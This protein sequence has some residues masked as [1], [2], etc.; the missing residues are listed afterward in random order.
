MKKIIFILFF[1]FASGSLYAELDTLSYWDKN[2]PTFVGFNFAQ[3]PLQSA[4]FVPEAPCYIKEIHAWYLG[5]PGSAVIWLLDQAGG[6]FLPNAL[7][8]TAGQ[9]NINA[10]SFNVNPPPGQIGGVR[11][12]L[13]EPY[14]MT[15]TQFYVISGNH[16]QGLLLASDTTLHE[17]FCEYKEGDSDVQWRPQ[18]LSNTNGDWMYGPYAYL[19]DV[20]VEYPEKESK[21]YLQDITSQVELPT[22]MGRT[23]YAW[24]DFDGDG[25]LDF[26]NGGRYFKNNEGESFTEMTQ[27]LGL[28]GS[29]SG[30]AFV[31]MDND[32]DLDIVLLK[33]SGAKSYLYTNDGEGGLTETQLEGIPDLVDPTCFSFADINGDAYPDLFIGQLW[34]PYPDPQPNYFL[35]NNQNG[36][37]DYL[38]DVCKTDGDKQ[39]RGSQFV[40]FDDDGDLDLYVT[41]YFLQMDELWENEGDLNF[42]NIIELTGISQNRG[43]DHNYPSNHGTGVDWYDYDNDG[44]MDILLCQF[45][46]PRFIGESIDHRPTT[47]YKNLEGWYDFEDTYDP[48]TWTSN[49]GLGFTESYAGASW[50]DANNDGLAD[51]VNT[52]FYRCQYI[53]FYEQQPDHTFENKTFEYGLEWIYTGVDACWVDYD[54][55][56]RLDLA[57]SKDNRFVLFKNMTPAD[58]NWVEIDLEASSGNKYAI[59]SRVK[60]YAGDD[61]YMQEVNCG[62]GQKM[63]RPYRLHFGLG[64]HQT[65][66][67]I[68][69]RWHGKTE[70]TTYAGENIQANS[71]IKLTETASDVDEI[72]EGEFYLSESRPNPVENAAALT[73]G[74]P[75]P[76][77]I[78]LEIYDSFGKLIRTLDSGFKNAGEHN[79]TFNVGDAASGAYYLKLSSGEQS[80]TTRLIISK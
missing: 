21:N 77:E 70:Y 2:E 12:V 58:N 34:S 68:E 80:E 8:A 54:N 22:N 50:G 72:A 44:D 28:K 36:D 78:R 75:K 49:V 51:Y 26:L 56:G 7:T 20:V 27:D 43:G 24:T 59:G 74:L 35:V 31:D 18:N 1:C 15:D 32:G 62:R 66:D 6:T 25:Y 63:Q 38:D 57:M 69:V 60:V 71:I 42:F 41:N 9:Y 29:A 4:R 76:A 40:D 52:V 73:Y 39:S 79:L 33:S 53:D 46:H 55:D 19:V 3:Y 13:D 67:K 45:A 5:Q 23:T 10:W 48:D 16:S 47:I 14:Y 61:V 30:N 64:S 37:F 17:V 11:I 65:I